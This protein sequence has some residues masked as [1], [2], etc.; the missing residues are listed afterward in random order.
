MLKWNPDVLVPRGP[1]WLSIKTII[2]IALAI[3]IG[4]GVW[5]FLNTLPSVTTPPVVEVPVTPPVVEV[6][7]PPPPL[8][9]DIPSNF[10]VPDE[11]WQNAFL[12]NRADG[13]EVRGAV[14]FSGIP[15]GT[16]LFAPVDGWHVHVF[17]IEVAG[18]DSFSNIIL[19]QDPNPN[20]EK[21][22]DPGFQRVELEGA[23]INVFN[24]NPKKGEAFAEVEATLP[25]PSRY[26][27]KEVSFIVATDNIWGKGSDR[28]ITDPRAYLKTTIENIN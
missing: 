24:F 26:F 13:T 6:P 14:G 7:P 27:D 2:A 8:P 1:S 20:W 23:S 17:A 9:P 3:A 18:M 4:G 16:Q 5:W 12:L 25:Y 11:V 21:A 19:T 15:I 28:S 22:D 10:I